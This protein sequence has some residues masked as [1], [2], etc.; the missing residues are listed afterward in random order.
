MYGIEQLLAA[1]VSLD[2]TDKIEADGRANGSLIEKA[3]QAAEVL[4]ANAI[5]AA[6]DESQRS[7]S[8]SNLRYNGSQNDCRKRRG[9]SVVQLPANFGEKYTLAIL[10]SLYIIV[11]YSNWCKT[12]RRYYR[13][14]QL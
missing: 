11:Y 12:P 6:A 14:R 4:P 13:I 3:F 1:A 9:S 8:S 7:T 2:L 5:E 10:Y